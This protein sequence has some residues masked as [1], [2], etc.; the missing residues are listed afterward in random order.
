[1]CSFL[2]F[3]VLGSFGEREAGDVEQDRELRL[4]A[5]RRLEAAKG[6]QRPH[7]DVLDQRIRRLR[8]ERVEDLL[9]VRR[10]R[11]ELYVDADLPEPAVLAR[12][13]RLDGRDAA[14][15]VLDCRANEILQLG[16]SEIR[17]RVA[18]EKAAPILRAQRLERLFQLRS[19]RRDAA[20]DL[21]SVLQGVD[22]RI[23]VPVEQEERCEQ[24]RDAQEHGK[25]EQRQSQYA[26]LPGRKR[27]REG[28]HQ[29]SS[30]GSDAPGEGG[31]AASRLAAQSYRAA[32][33]RVAARSPRGTDRIR[34]PSWAKSF[35]AAQ[36]ASA[37]TEL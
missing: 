37:P 20:V 18:Q 9:Q 17:R 33:R 35:R 4:V 28:D 19:L 1:M 11:E 16:A 8:F 26:A 21:D 22:R 32:S 6:V 30:S 5:W 15:I 10:A 7:G 3:S 34:P 29:L 31:A 12:L 36:H 14:A 27:E 13:R 23:V 2:R 25:R 24:Q